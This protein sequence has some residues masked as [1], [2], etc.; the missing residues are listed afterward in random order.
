MGRLDH[1]TALVTG[2]ASGLGKAIAQRLVADGANVVIT[3]VQSDLGCTTAS[4]CGCIFLEQDV[5]EETRWTQVVRE[6]EE[7]FGQLDILVNNAG[8]LGPTDAVN[9]ENSRLADWKR[10]FAV[11]VDG[12]FLGCRAAIP[13]MRRAGSGSIINISSVAGLLASPYATAYGAS[14]AAVRQ[15]TKS[16]AQHCAQ[17]KL[18]IRCNSVHPGVVRTPLWN[19][20][21][22]ET[23]RARGVS[24][25]EIVALGMAVVPMGDFTLPEDVS[26]VVSFLASQDARHVTGARL[27]V[28]GGIVNCDTYHM[29]SR[30]MPSAPRPWA[31][32][33]ESA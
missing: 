27:I 18:N 12:V 30:T 32:G 3:D 19:K 33:L 7:R 11:N 25:E 1:K 9:P 20:H 6:I 10:T 22:E 14:K 4:E 31:N 13:A 28:D 21:A 16:V 24:L 2:G 5:C 29:D 23:A 15:L 17:E 8:V 26:A